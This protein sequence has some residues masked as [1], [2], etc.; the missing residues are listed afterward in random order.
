MRTEARIFCVVAAFLYAVT[1]VYAFWT[2]RGARVEWTGT[3]ALLL[4]ATLCLMCGAY[5]AFV[6][7]RIEPRPEDRDADIA[8]GAGTVG[9]FAPHSYWP[10]G[11]ALASTVAAAGVVFWQ[12]WLLLIGIAGVLAAVGGLLF[13]YYTGARRAEQ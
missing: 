7:R 11:I 13:E 9:F 10:A 8:E 6:S 5:F 12:S 3:V 4:S 1:G 2:S